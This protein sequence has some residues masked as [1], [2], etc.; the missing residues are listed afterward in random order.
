MRPGARPCTPAHARQEGSGVAVAHGSRPLTGP[1]P[2]PR[3]RRRRSAM[4]ADA[5]AGAF[6]AGE[7]DPPAMAL[8]AQRALGDRRKWLVELARTVFAGFPERP[9]DR[10]RELAAFIGACDV[11]S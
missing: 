4:V 8:R 3:S 6:L 11:L 9:I 5:L 7:W 10:P 2:R 1:G